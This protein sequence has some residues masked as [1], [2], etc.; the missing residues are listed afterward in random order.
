[1]NSASATAAADADPRTAA[2]AAQ[3]RAAQAA[4]RAGDADEAALRRRAKRQA[5]LLMA[6]SSLVTIA[7]L[8][9]AW[10]LFR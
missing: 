7:L 10:L 3:P 8:A 1:M 4:W 2:H 6:A 5:L 9:G